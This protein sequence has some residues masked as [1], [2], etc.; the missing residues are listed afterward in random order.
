[1]KGERDT[2]G[3]DRSIADLHA[4]NLP[5]DVNRNDVLLVPFSIDLP[6]QA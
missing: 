6:Y 2:F 4:R 1:M 5:I 3:E